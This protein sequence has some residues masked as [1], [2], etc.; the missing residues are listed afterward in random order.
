M[1][2]NSGGEEAADTTENSSAA[3]G[4]GHPSTRKNKAAAVAA[5]RTLLGQH[6]YLDSEKSDLG[7]LAVALAKIATQLKKSRTATKYGEAVQAVSTLIEDVVVDGLAERVAALVTS[8][9][10]IKLSDS[11]TK[12]ADTAEMLKQGAAASAAKSTEAH[13]R[14]ERLTGAME[15]AC[16][17]LTDSSNAFAFG[18]TDRQI[19]ATLGEGTD[20]GRCAQTEQGAGAARTSY[21]DVIKATPAEHID[22]IART[23]LTRRQVIMRRDPAASSDAFAELTEKELVTKAQLAVQLLAGTD[24]EIPDNIDFLHARRTAGGGVVLVMKTEEAAEWLRSEKV[25]PR[26]ARELGG[27]TT[28]APTLCMVIAEYV[29]VAFNPE[30]KYAL[31]SVERDS[32]LAAGAIREARYLKKIERR[33]QGQRVAHVMVGLISPEQA[34]IA[35]RKGL[36][37]EGKKVA[38]RRHRMDPKRCMKCQGIGVNHN[39]AACK[40]IHDV[41]ARCA[42]MHRTDE[43]LVSDFADFK[44]ANCKTKGHGAADRDCPAFKEK[45]RILHAR[46]PNYA[47]RFFPT[48]DPHTWEKE[49]EWQDG[50]AQAPQEKPRDKQGDR[51]EALVKRTQQTNRGT[52]PT[53]NGWPQR[54]QQQRTAG[55]KSDGTQGGGGTTTLKQ[56]KV[57]D[58]FAKAS[59]QGTQGPPSTRP[60]P[61]HWDGIGKDVLAF[62]GMGGGDWADDGMEDLYY[63]TPNTNAR[64]P[65]P[66]P[67]V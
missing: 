37:I 31:E 43:C 10:E 14:V 15:K 17:S 61:P 8:A 2:Q 50:A 1:E 59:T 40:S 11:Y 32:G 56:A 38:A 13:E 64:S 29:P 58:M 26:F 60:G 39:A 34:N 55:G 42:E 30:T 22:A 27:M 28:A 53:D 65:R 54:T 67:H 25:M 24:L 41:C 51:G 62:S 21:A 5:A 16:Q 47:Y 63:S 48:A 20:G 12:L 9:V 36:V 35:I 52:R 66:P 49:G 3:L 18:M 44:C 46:M 33:A 7:S 23:E 19:A 57:S 6:K 45:A 4:A